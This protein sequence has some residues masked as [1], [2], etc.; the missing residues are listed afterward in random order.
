M[1][2]YFTLLLNDHAGDT[3]AMTASA[4]GDPPEE[5]ERSV[6]IFSFPRPER[7]SL[8][9]PNVLL[10]D[11][12]GLDHDGFEDAVRPTK[13]DPIQPCFVADRALCEA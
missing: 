2:G 8:L 13:S 10:G 11:N 5:A 6:P 7:R 9:M 4:S 12:T 3:G 1:P